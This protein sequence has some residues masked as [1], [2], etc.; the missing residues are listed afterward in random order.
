MPAAA[1]KLPIRP[2]DAYLVTH[3][4]E[5]ASNYLERQ[6]IRCERRESTIYSTNGSVGMEAVR[7]MRNANLAQRR[8]ERSAHITVDGVRG[9]CS[10][11]QLRWWLPAPALLAIPMPSLL[12]SEVFT[13]TASSMVLRKCGS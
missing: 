6:C 13:E 8:A 1:S 7:T 12:V 3:A 11:P 9:G 2:Q 4:E 5:A 10:E